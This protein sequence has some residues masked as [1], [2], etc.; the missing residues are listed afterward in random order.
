[1]RIFFGKRIGSFFIGASVGIPHRPHHQ[2]ALP[3]Q[4]RQ[5]GVLEVLFWAAMLAC[6]LIGWL[7]WS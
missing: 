2:P 1:M 3:M 6:L 5:P 7:A 4:R